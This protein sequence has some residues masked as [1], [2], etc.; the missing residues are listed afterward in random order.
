MKKASIDRV[1]TTLVRYYADDSVTV[2]RHRIDRARSEGDRKDERLW[3]S[4]SE[5]IRHRLSH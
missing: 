3:R 2:V 4:V 1:A 5:E